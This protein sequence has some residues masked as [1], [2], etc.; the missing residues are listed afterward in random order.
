M[1]FRFLRQARAMAVLL[2]AAALLALPACHRAASKEEKALRSELRQALDEQNYERAADLARRHLKSKPHDNGIWDRL[3]RAQ[4]G[5]HDLTGVKQTL[6]KWRRTVPKPSP[7]LDEYAGDL[8]AA[9]KDDAAAIEAWKSVAAAAPKN[10]RVLEKI[11]RLEKRRQFWTKEDAAWTALLAVQ[12]SASARINRAL[13]RRRLHRWHDAFEDLEKARALAAD[14]PEVQRGAKLLDGTGKF[15]AE[16]RE[17]DSAL[18]ISPNDAGLLA[19]RALLFLRAEDAE[20]ALED[21]EAAGKIGTWAVRPKLFQALAL[22]AL[23]R[24][25]ECEKLGVHKLIRL[26]ALAPEFLE[27]TGRLDSEI[28]AERSNA[29]LYVSRAWQLNEIG[30]PILALEDAETAVKLDP[31]AAGACAEASYALTKLG[32]AQEALDHI[33]R[34]TELDPNFS[35]AWQYR[36]E[37]EMARGEI[38]SAIDSFT[39]ALETNQTVTALEK[40]EQCYRRLGLL[41]KAEQDR[42]ARVELART[43]K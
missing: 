24:A 31:K 32:R 28:S 22:I 19:D 41:V 36:G 11:A 7:N 39:H 2:M 35:T 25:D 33:K 43:S 6:D 29:E 34:A 40:R 42:R 23:G 15:L 14:D 27:T 4:F 26:E 16:I 17:L 38:L 13:C 8:A 18:A 10:V 37:L 1:R 3:T 5:L 20:L 12:E 21:A 9:Q 30:Q